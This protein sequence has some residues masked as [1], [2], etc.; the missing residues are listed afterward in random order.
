MTLGHEQL[1][2]KIPLF[3]AYRLATWELTGGAHACMLSA[4]LC[5]RTSALGCGVIFQGAELF[6]C[7]DYA[8]TGLNLLQEG[9]CIL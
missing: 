9:L 3:G 5:M 2:Q 1:I 4:C 6:F 7:C 8:W